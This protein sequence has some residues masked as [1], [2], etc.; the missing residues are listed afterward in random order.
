MVVLQVE[1][2]VVVVDDL[3][4]KLKIGEFDLKLVFSDGCTGMIIGVDGADPKFSSKEKQI[5]SMEYVFM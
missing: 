4:L 5:D 3:E 1:T 2:L